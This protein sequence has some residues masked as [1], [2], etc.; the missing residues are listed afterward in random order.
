MPTP[1]R[2]LW[3]LTLAALALGPLGGCAAKQKKAPAPAPA[4]DAGQVEA[5]KAAAAEAQGELA[6]EEAT[7]E[8]AAKPAA[9]LTH[10]KAVVASAEHTGAAGSGRPKI[11][12]KGEAP[13]GWTVKVDASTVD[14]K[15]TLTV[16]AHPPEGAT[17]QAANKPYEH[18]H[19]MDR[20]KGGPWKIHAMNEKGAE[21]KYFEFSY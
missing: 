9:A 20:L 18:V 11:T 14:Q 13:E 17:E 12:I 3:T 16:W 6:K 4:P 7:K 2:A 10:I 21:I 15:I 5:T 8:E 1:K 19:V